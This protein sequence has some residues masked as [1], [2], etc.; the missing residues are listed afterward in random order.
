M[1]LREIG[2]LLEKITIHYPAYTKHISDGSGKMRR[3]V[4]E[5]WHRLIGFLSFKDAMERLDAYMEDP[6]N[7][8]PPMA[9]DF[10]RYKSKPK[11]ETFHA[12]IEH[13]WHL[14]FMKHDPHCMHGR[15]YDQEEREYV[16]DP[17]YEDGYHYDQEGRI[18]TID[19]RVIH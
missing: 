3:D 11:D 15:M 5:E 10:K 16:H 4:A 19:G 17:T 7:K 2:N 14:E 1:D 8:R 6:D 13:Q 18:C 9:A 12:P